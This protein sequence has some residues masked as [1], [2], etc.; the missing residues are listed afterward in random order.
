[1]ADDS[2]A[3]DLC[4]LADAYSAGEISHD[5]FRKRMVIIREAR[6]ERR[7]AQERQVER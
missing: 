3:K 2:Y 7:Q 5:E 6:I 4:T 1:V